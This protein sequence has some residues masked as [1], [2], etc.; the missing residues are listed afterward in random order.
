MQEL[1]LAGRMK[2]PHAPRVN[3]GKTASIACADLILH[4][5]KLFLTDTFDVHNIFYTF[6]RAVLRPIINNRLRR[7]R[8]HTAD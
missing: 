2:K 1:R 7:L 4:R 5:I 8:P 3:P 6:K